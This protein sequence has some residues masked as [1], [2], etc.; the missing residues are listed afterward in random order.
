MNITVMGK[1]KRRRRARLPLERA[2]RRVI[3]LGRGGGDTSEAMR[4]LPPSR[5][6]PSPRRSAG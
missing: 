4:S 1:K 2:D 5:L 6:T 3:R